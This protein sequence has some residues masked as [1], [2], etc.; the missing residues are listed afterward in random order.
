MPEPEPDDE[1]RN[2][3]LLVGRLAAEPESRELPSGTVITTFRLVVRR[4]PDLRERSRPAESRAPSVDTLD[5]VAWRG[6]VRRHLSRW[7][8][9]DVVALE[10]ALRR[11]FWRSPG[12][13]ASRTEVE[14]QKV[15]RVARAVA[16]AG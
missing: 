7:H 5:C 2:E 1:H 11:R 3:V 10:G 8:P 4:E 15:R 14:A 13:P 16:Q 12:G 6:D 9:G